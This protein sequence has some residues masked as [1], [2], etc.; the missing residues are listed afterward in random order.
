MYVIWD[1]Y[2]N[3]RVAIIGFISNPN[4]KNENKLGIGLD[5]IQ[6]M[7]FGDFLVRVTDIWTNKSRIFDI[8]GFFGQGNWHLDE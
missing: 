3:F 7:C 6:K 2:Y 4:L 5:D 1:N 8:F